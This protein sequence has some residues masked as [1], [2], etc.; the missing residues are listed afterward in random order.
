VTETTRVTIDIDVGSDPISG[1][2][3]IP[4]GRAE[5]FVGWSALAE[6]LEEARA[7]MAS[8][9]ARPAAADPELPTS[10]GGANA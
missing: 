7:G 6:L 9:Y 1:S 5:P 8:R 2:V 4:G 10:T 3:D